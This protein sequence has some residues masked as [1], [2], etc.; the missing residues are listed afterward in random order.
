MD[1]KYENY[2]REDFLKAIEHLT[3]DK[4]DIDKYLSVYLSG[5]ADGLE[6]ARK[7]YNE[8]DKNIFKEFSGSSGGK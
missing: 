1:N 6:K 2:V 4:K 5:R 3:I 8:S 7:I